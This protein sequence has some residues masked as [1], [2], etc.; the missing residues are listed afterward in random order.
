MNDRVMLDL[1]INRLRSNASSTRCDELAGILESLGFE[2]REGKKQ[3]HKIFVHHDVD[4]FTSAAYTC[5][6][7]RNPEIKP[8]Y[9]RKVASLLR[10]YEAE[11]VLYLGEG[12]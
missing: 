6:H 7:G 8:V 2:V 4:A 9:V 1:V 12:R 3:G 5:G 10:Q 11:L